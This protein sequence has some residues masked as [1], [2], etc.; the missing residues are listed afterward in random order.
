MSNKQVRKAK[1]LG[2]QTIEVGDAIIEDIN[3]E[4]TVEQGQ[5]LLKALAARDTFDRP[6]I[7]KAYADLEKQ[8]QY[9]Q[10]FVD[11]TEYL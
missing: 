3:K 11:F 1:Q 6:L 8:Y 9:A 5:S 4:I 10:T 2:L 7:E